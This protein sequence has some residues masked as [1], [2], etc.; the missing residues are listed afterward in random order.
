MPRRR[1]GQ[2]V[3]KR[4]RGRH[5]GWAVQRANIQSIPR[6]TFKPMSIVRTSDYRCTFRVNLG[7]CANYPSPKPTYDGQDFNWFGTLNINSIFPWM[8]NGYTDAQAFDPTFAFDPNNGMYHVEHGSSGAPFLVNNTSF[9]GAPP[10]ACP[11]GGLSY[12]QM[13][14]RDPTSGNLLYQ[15]TVAPGLFT[16]EDDVGY[17]YAE[18][19]V[20]GSKLTLKFVPLPSQVD[21][22]SAE[23]AAT[24][25]AVV[26]HDTE[27]GELYCFLHTQS[28]QG[29]IDA[30]CNKTSRWQDLKD[31]PYMRA[32]S[33]S[34]NVSSQGGP[35][36]QYNYTT[37]KQGNAAVLQYK[38]GASTVHQT[39]VLDQDDFWTHTD[40]T[41]GFKNPAELDHLTFGI[42]RHL[43]GPSRARCAPSGFIELRLE[44]IIMLRKPM[45][46][47]TIALAQ[48]PGNLGAGGAAP[49]PGVFPQSMMHKGHAIGV[50]LGALHV[51]SNLV[52]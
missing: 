7:A 27:P 52:N 37:N 43:T 12:T 23:R 46:T 32:R 34:S 45:S 20:L 13:T 41:N 1:Y 9:E 6:L 14:A 40:A 17:Q 25:S 22:R 33:I 5:S 29:A 24:Q 2:S 15:P 18:I 51:A 38:Y 30:L 3:F 4:K 42:R 8:R 49:G 47:R 39:D 11:P 48:Q 28:A 19:A 26:G 10:V 50:G 44:Q 21:N 35:G 16:N 36:D 31:L